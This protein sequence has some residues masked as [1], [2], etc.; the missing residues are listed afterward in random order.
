MCFQEI[1]PG[2]TVVVR[3]LMNEK[4]GIQGG[5]RG[6][7]VDILK[8]EDGSLYEVHADSG[9]QC[10]FVRSEIRGLIGKEKAGLTGKKP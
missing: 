8:S 1:K 7:V 5:D 9:K 2:D 10:Y 3:R 4:P 6:V